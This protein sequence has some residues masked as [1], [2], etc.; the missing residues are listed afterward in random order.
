MQADQNIGVIDTLRTG[1]VIGVAELP[2]VAGKSRLQVVLPFGWLTGAQSRCELVKRLRIC[3]HFGGARLEISSEFVSDLLEDFE[4]PAG[5]GITRPLDRIEGRVK[6]RD[7]ASE[8]AGRCEKAS[9]NRPPPE[10]LNRV[11]KNRAG[12]RVADDSI[13]HVLA[14][15]CPPGL[16]GRPDSERTPVRALSGTRGE[17][18]REAVVAVGYLK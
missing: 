7:Q 3:W 9:A 17:G 18:E 12:Q 15:D 1:R 2:L 4:V 13:D 6:H 10:R 14:S 5:D 16:T 11:R 8:A